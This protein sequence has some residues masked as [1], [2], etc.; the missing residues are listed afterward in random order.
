MRYARIYR[1]ALFLDR[2]ID[3]YKH[4]RKLKNFPHK[5]IETVIPLIFLG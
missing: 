2:F 5:A 3:N 1:K 4:V